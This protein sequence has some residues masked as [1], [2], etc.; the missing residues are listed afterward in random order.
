MRDSLCGAVTKAEGMNTQAAPIYSD[1]R[2]IYFACSLRVEGV[3]Q[4]LV[5]RKSRSVYTAAQE[6]LD[7]GIQRTSRGM[8]Y[9]ALLMSVGL[10]PD[11]LAG[12]V[13][14]QL[15]GMQAG[16]RCWK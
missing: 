10:P 1:R 9:R 5:T 16:V 2:A 3:I 13:E 12:M 8:A 11:E 6:V 4:R 7:H 14:S 15:G